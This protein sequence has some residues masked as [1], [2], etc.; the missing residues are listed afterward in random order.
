M[1]RPTGRLC[2]CQGV[3]VSPLLEKDGEA[4]CHCLVAVT[5]FCGVESIS[6]GIAD[7]LASADAAHLSQPGHPIEV[8][9]DQT[10][11]YERSHAL[12]SFDQRFLRHV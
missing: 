3:P 5:C 4:L 9:R 2:S 8:G 11:V 6:D 12:T 1:R 7:E 10:G